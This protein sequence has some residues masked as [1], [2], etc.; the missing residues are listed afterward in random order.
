MRVHYWTR[1]EILVSAV[2]CCSAIAFVAGYI[3]GLHEL[4]PTTSEL[5]RSLETQNGNVDLLTER[6]NAC[7]A[8]LKQ[9]VEY[10]EAQK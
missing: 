3:T 5:T 9:Y 6:L 1:K 10:V 4:A 2:V 8:K 7:S